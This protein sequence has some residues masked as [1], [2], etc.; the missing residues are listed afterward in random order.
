M[1]SPAQDG[2]A[3]PA[4]VGGSQEGGQG[5]KEKPGLVGGPEPR[6]G[7]AG[8]TDPQGAQHAILG[9]APHGPRGGWLGPP[10]FVPSS[11]GTVAA[12]KGLVLA[13]EPNRHV[14]GLQR[15]ERKA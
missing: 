7:G 10:T 2:E 6:R 11:D 14:P 13:G 9:Q 12:G 4:A 8:N 5:G 15:R 1:V 3:A